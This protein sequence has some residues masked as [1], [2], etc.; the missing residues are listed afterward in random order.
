MFCND[1]CFFEDFLL[2]STFNNMLPNNDFCFIVVIE[3]CDV[4]GEIFHDRPYF[5]E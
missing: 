3:T 5:N 2:S 1:N 4:L